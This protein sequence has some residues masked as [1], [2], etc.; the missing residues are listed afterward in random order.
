MMAVQW[1]AGVGGLVVSLTSFQDGRVDFRDGSSP[2]LELAIFQQHFTAL[3]EWRSK[4]A[5]T[6]VG[7]I[8][9]QVVKNMG[10]VGRHGCGREMGEGR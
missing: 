6:D 10:R 5:G 9:V 7:V 8:D 4:L 1:W 3:D 2:V